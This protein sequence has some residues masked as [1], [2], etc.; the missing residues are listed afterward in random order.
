M[1]YCILHYYPL[2]RRLSLR[3]IETYLISDVD[4]LNGFSKSSIPDSRTTNPHVQDQTSDL[5]VHDGILGNFR[6]PNR[7][8]DLYILGRVVSPD[9]LIK[10]WDPILTWNP[11]VH[12][13]T[14]TH[15]N[16]GYKFPT[17]KLRL[18]RRGPDY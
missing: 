4:V 15:S 9:D 13:R 1:S 5:S 6:G 18:R 14:V 10:T 2:F 16:F 3:N 17:S 8:S 7:I 11:D 12:S